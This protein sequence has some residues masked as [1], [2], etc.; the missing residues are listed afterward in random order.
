MVPFTVTISD[1]EKDKH[2]PEK[3][4]SELDGILA[5]A[6]RGCL[7]WQRVGLA[8]PNEV[9]QATAT[10]QA[11]QDIVQRFICECCLVHPAVRV[12]ASAL[13]EAYQHWSGDRLM[14]LHSFGQR[15]RDKG[16]QSKRG[17][18]GRYFWIGI[19]FASDATGEQ[20]EQDSNDF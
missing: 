17:H 6:A 1:E 18:G 4:K 12:K 11:E 5:W 20:G 10:Y 9:R 2:L 3:L 13:L 15:L 14:S 19:G 7:D 8:E 16:F